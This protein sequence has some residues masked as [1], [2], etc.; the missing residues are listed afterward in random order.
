MQ[1]DSFKL[2]AFQH[3]QQMIPCFFAIAAWLSINFT[4][5]QS[6]RLGGCL[7]MQLHD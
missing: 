2:K 6:D 1:S 4:A 3:Q 5:L 7:I